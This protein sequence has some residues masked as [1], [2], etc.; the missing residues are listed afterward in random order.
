MSDEASITVTG[1]EEVCA[2]LTLMPTRLVKHA[3]AR[4]VAAASAVVVRELVA[5]APEHTG[6]MKQHVVSVIAVA[7]DGTGASSY[8]GF[9]KHGFKALLVEFGHRMLGHAPSKKELR[10]PVSA[11]PFMRPTVAACA[12]EAVT[13]FADSLAESIRSGL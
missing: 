11:R 5:R 1:L 6:K 7:A 9:G 13:A 3:Y 12:E 2:A 10:D 8:I 4:A